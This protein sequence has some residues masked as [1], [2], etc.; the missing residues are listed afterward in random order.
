ML[1]KRF[2]TDILQSDRIEHTADRFCNS[3]GRIPCFWLEGQPLGDD[4]ADFFQIEKGRI[5]FAVAKG[6]GSRHDRIA[7][8]DAGDFNSHVGALDSFFLQ[9]THDAHPPQSLF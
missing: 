4:R 7:E 8:L 6:S 2:D 3:R 1:D 9:L 5:F